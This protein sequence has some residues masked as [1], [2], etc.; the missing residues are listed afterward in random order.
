M[1]HLRAGSEEAR[2]RTIPPGEGETVFSKNGKNAFKVLHVRD[3]K[4]EPVLTH[5]LRDQLKVRHLIFTGVATSVCVGTTAMSATE[6]NFDSILVA[7]ACADF[8]PDRHQRTLEMF[9]LGR[10]Q[11]SDLFGSVIHSTNELIEALE[12]M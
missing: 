8:F 9:G 12:I 11:R 7:D 4:A 3:G 1:K 10:S 2:L 5:I 6:E